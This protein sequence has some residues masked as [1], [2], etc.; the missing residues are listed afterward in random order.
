MRYSMRADTASPAPQR[1]LRGG[2]PRSH[3][4]SHRQPDSP[5]DLHSLTLQGSPIRPDSAGR[6]GACRPR[7]RQQQLLDMVA[8]LGRGM[9]DPGGGSLP[10]AGAVAPP[11]ADPG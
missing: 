11:E 8:D 10:V 5:A 7:T 2:Q 6:A 1:A 4:V 9:S 3:R